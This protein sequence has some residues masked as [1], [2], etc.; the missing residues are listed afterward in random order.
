MDRDRLD[1]LR[2]LEN[3]LHDAMLAAEPRAIAGIAKQYRETLAEIAEL[4]GAD[5]ERDEIAE[6][7]ASHAR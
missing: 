4:E 3:E 7:I 2:E 6:L 5:D 1:K